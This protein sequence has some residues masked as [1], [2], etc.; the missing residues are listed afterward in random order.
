MRDMERYNC[1]REPGSYQTQVN[2]CTAKTA[3]RTADIRHVV[4]KALG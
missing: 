2:G 4:E 1:P 3:Q